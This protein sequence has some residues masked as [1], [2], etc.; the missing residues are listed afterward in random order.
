MKTRRTLQTLAV[1]AAVMATGCRMG[2]PPEP[3]ADLRLVALSDLADPKGLAGIEAA[4]VIE[5][6]VWPD[7]P[8]M[9]FTAADLADTAAGMPGLGLV[10]HYPTRLAVDVRLHQGR[11]A[12]GR[13]EWEI[14]QMSLWELWIERS[15]YPTDLESPQCPPSGGP[16]SG[17][18]RG[19]WRFPGAEDVANVEDEALWLVLWRAPPP[20][21]YGP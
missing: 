10:D 9:L 7:G 20:Y 4:V 3:V 12:Q 14:K 11:V 19:I 13:V 6:T 1:A 21:G 2:V 5:G 8:E 16:P 17:E 18:C 15:L